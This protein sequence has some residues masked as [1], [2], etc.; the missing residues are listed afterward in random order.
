VK[1]EIVLKQLLVF[2]DG[3]FDAQF[4]PPGL[5]GGKIIEEYALS[6]FHSL[7]HSQ[8]RRQTLFID[9]NP[10]CMSRQKIY[11]SLKTERYTDNSRLSNGF[12]ICSPFKYNRDDNAP[13]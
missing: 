11:A 8:L 7:Q 2:R 5:S 12:D 10:R 4:Q 9:Q 1:K 3:V 13:I 6:F